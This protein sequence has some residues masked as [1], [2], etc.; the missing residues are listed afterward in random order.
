MAIKIAFLIVIL[1]LFILAGSVLLKKS[2]RQYNSFTWSLVEL[3][4]YLISFLAVCLGLVE[5][6]R[7]EQTNAYRAEERR[8]NNAYEE[9]RNL[10]YA[11]TRLLKN[12]TSLQAGRQEGIRWFKR[13]KSLLDEGLH[14]RRWEGF[15]LFSR[16]YIFKDPGCYADPETNM[17]EFNWPSHLLSK[18]SDIYLREEIRWVIDGLVNLQRQKSELQAKIPQEN[19]NYTARYIIIF[20]YLVGLSLKI[21][22]IAADYKRSRQ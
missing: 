21:L 12:D 18:P 17:I 3:F 20:F 8:L 11:Q 10:L 22:K 2:I 4:W 6:Q 13:M 15:L 16:S 19:T 14:T 9:T 7:I 1:L 5:I